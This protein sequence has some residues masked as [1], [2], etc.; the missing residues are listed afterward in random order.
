MSGQPVRAATVWAGE[1]AFTGETGSGHRVALDGPPEFG[2]A[3]AGARPLELMLLAIGGCATFEVVRILRKGKQDVSHCVAE[4]TGDQA[5]TV[6][7]VFTRVHLRFRIAGRGL[8]PRKVE[9]AIRL[10]VE[11]YC[12]ASVCLTRAGVAVTHDYALVAP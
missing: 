5:E 4:L 7:R 6:P 11:K 8:R 12:P 10:T 3:N 1:A 9:R 2:G